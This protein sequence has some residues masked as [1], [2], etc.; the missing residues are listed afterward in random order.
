M[1]QYKQNFNAPDYSYLS[2][3]SSQVG[4]S[5]SISVISVSIENNEALVNGVKYHGETMASGFS[6]GMSPVGGYAGMSYTTILGDGT[7]IN[8]YDILEDAIFSTYED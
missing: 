7:A 8:I 5:G 2:G 6:Y 1:Y 4:A 3:E